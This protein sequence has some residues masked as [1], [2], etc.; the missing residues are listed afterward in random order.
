MMDNHGTYV[1]TAVA[2]HGYTGAYLERHQII[3]CFYSRS[4]SNIRTTYCYY[5]EKNNALNQA[6][7]HWRPFDLSPRATL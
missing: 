2:P 7:S 1:G 4:A 5:V 3:N 6:L